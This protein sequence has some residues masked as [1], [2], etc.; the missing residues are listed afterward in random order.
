MTPITVITGATGG[1]GA[2]LASAL[3]DHELILL[4]RDPAK[5]EALRASLPNAHAVALE[6]RE[7][8]GFA[9]ALERFGVVDN[10]VHNAGAVQ[11]GT[12]EATS[13]EV[14]RELLEV[15]LLAAVELTRVLLPRLRVARG[16][17]VLVNSGAGL[18]ANAGWS[19]YAAS[20]FALR[21]FA[22]SLALE[23]PLLRVQ[24]VYPGRTATGMQER[25]RAQEAAPYEAEKY[26]QPETLARTIRAMLELP[27]DSV[28]AQVV[29]NRPL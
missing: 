16:Q 9:P 23:E 1:I 24:S 6:L 22:E 15:N 20:K 27:R 10:L 19:G 2:S 18:V 3:Q 29:V 13:L 12:V 11:L 14:W 5:L 26:I 17:V 28:M 8:E 4:G 25:V 7:P 21:A